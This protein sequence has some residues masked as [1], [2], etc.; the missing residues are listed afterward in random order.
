MGPKS[1]RSESERA[2]LKIG[3]RVAAREAIEYRPTAF[4]VRR[5]VTIAKGALGTIV[6]PELVHPIYRVAWDNAPGFLTTNVESLDVVLERERHRAQRMGE[7]TCKQCGCS[8]KD[9]CP[10]GCA[11]VST[12]ED[13]CTGCLP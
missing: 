3:D 13:L 7:R 6:A 12:G 4:A 8:E 1:Q 2:H 11:W 10:G 5:A 9:A